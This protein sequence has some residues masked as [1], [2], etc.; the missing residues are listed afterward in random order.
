MSDTQWPRW[1]VFKQDG[2]K[3]PHQAVGTVHAADAE[4]ALLAARNV[5]VRR[6]HAVSL[7]V[8]PAERILTVTQELL[9][10][11]ESLK[12]E[13]LEG[14]APLKTYTEVRG[15][16][17]RDTASRGRYQVFC[18]TSYKPSLSFADYQGE[19]E[20]ESPQ[21]ALKRARQTFLVETPLAWMIVPEDAIA[22]THDEDVPS[23]FDPAKDKTYKQQSAYGAVKA[24]T[25][26]KTGKAHSS[27]RA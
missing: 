27:G 8:A 21:G 18:K 6:P 7:W 16:E 9:R 26:P 15:T 2:P 11:D 12:L 4:H 1:E 14:E 20:A 5:F 24:K 25:N 23:W 10:S 22:R 13:V 17:V 3:R 19:L